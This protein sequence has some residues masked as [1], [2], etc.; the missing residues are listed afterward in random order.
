MIVVIRPG[1]SII[2]YPESNQLEKVMC[3]LCQMGSIDNSSSAD[4]IQCHFG[5][6]NVTYVSG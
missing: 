6:V 5:K 2:T 1:F 3:D 4:H